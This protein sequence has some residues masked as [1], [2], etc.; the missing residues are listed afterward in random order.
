MS[1]SQ[2]KKESLFNE[3]MMKLDAIKSCLMND[4][5][6]GD[7]SPPENAPFG[8]Y[9][10]SSGSTGDWEKYSGQLAY[11]IEGWKFIKPWDGLILFQKADKNIY[12]FYDGSWKKFMP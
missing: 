12:V 11:Y 5:L 4:P 1:Q 6:I 9:V 3:C 8:L 2:D 7:K 10:I